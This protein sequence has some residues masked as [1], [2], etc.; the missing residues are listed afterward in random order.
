V[1][2]LDVAVPLTV[3]VVPAGIVE[4]PLTVKVTFVLG[5]ETI[6]PLVGEMIDTNKVVDRFT[7]MTAVSLPNALLQTTATVFGPSARLTLLDVVLVVEIP[8]TVQVVP[9]GIDV[10]PLTVNTTLVVVV[11]TKL[12]LMGAVIT[13]AGDGTLIFVAVSLPEPN[14]LVQVTTI[15]KAPGVIATVFVVGVVETFPLTVQV[16]PAGIVLEPFTM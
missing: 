4:P 13:T 8:L 11:V 15:V 12:L 7:V 2:V 1:V 3:Q 6:A 10:D 14:A 9:A 5:G 16:V